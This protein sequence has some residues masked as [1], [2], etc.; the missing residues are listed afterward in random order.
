MNSVLS[1]VGRML[2]E[3][4]QLLD[5]TGCRLQGLYEFRETLY[6]SRPVMSILRESPQLGSNVFVAPSANVIGKVQLG[7]NSSVWYGAIV[8]GDVAPIS[9]GNNTNIQDNAVIH[10][11]QATQNGA[12]PAHP[13]MI[14]SHVTIGHG[15]TVHGAT[16]EDESLIGMG[17]TVLDG[18]VVERHSMVAAGAVVPPNTRVKAGQVWAGNPAKYL[19]DLTPEEVAFLSAS[20]GNYVALAGKHRE[21]N[22]KTF[23]EVERDKQV[24][25]ERAAGLGQPETAPA[26]TQSGVPVTH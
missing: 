21:E 7:A 23:E 17:A 14:G 24:S 10:V 11:S 5:R 12:K 22:A 9:I 8:R 6:R 26:E 15:A 25:R 20:A 19:R 3:T 1:A 18:A 16:V 4:G 13:V 2:R